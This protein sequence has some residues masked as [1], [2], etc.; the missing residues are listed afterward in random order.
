[1]TKRTQA[2][3]AMTQTKRPK[4]TYPIESVDNALRLLLMFN[5]ATPIR[6]SDAADALGVARSTAHRLLAMLQYHGFVRQD[7][8]SRA[9]VAGPALFETS[10]SIVRQLDIRTEARPH[11]EQLGRDTNETIHLALAQGADI[12]FVDAVEGSMPVRVASR[13]GAVM[14]AHCTSVG[15]AILAALP[16]YEV[17]SYYDG[18]RLPQMTSHAIGTKTELRRE[19]ER[20]RE[21]GYAVSHEEAEEGVGSVSAAIMGPADRAFAAVSIAAPVTRLDDT[22]I[23]E[24]AE[25]A[26]TATKALSDKMI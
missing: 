24:F 25:L 22:R 1:M 6:A 21:E 10:L 16:W 18:E 17:S 2:Q 12:V 13:I 8:I 5:R 9:Y 26:V 23:A 11:L 14:P 4:P 3:P 19:L 7:P 15:K 20:V